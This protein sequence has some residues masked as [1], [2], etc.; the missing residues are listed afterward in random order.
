[1]VIGGLQRFSLSDFPG[2]ISAIV[3]T[4]GC[5]FR[6][7]YCHNPELV[8]PSRYAEAFPVSEVMAFL[9]SRAVQ[10]QGVVVTG[11]EPTMQQDLPGFLAELK[12]MGL[13]VKLDTNGTNPQL[14]QQL[15]DER[16][17]DFIAMDIKAPLALYAQM[18]RTPVRTSDILQ[19]VGLILASGLPHEFRTTCVDSLL[20]ESDILSIGGLLEGCNRYVLQ[21]FRG[22]RV[23]DQSLASERPPDKTR[24]GRIVAALSSAGIP[25]ETR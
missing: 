24:L 13:A 5:S 6:C 22:G 12:D 20:S 18:V 14:L 3:F 8:D 2:M 15:V 16:L 10:L 7:P 23:L 1:M 19:S 21:S 4:R 25:V 11:G 17:V 9:R